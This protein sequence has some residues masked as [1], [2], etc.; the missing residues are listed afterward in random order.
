MNTDPLSNL[1][2]E[3][4]SKINRMFSGCEEIVGIGHVA[5]VI[6]G[7][8]SHSGSNQLNAY[9]G[10]EPSG[11]AHLGWM[12]L[13]ETIDNLLSEKVNVT[14]LL[15][16][17]HAWVND[18]FSRDMEK[19]SLAADYMSEVFR[20]LLDFPDEG[21]GPG[22]L[23]F[24]RASEMMDSGLHD[25]TKFLQDTLF[26]K[27]GERPLRD[28]ETTIPDIIRSE[29]IENALTR[30]FRSNFEFCGG[31]EFYQKKIEELRE[32]RRRQ[33]KPQGKTESDFVSSSS[34]AAAAANSVDL[35]DSDSPEL[36]KAQMKRLMKKFLEAE[37]A[38]EKEK[39]Q[40]V[41]ARTRSGEK[42]KKR[43]KKTE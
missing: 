10:L 31:S 27:S 28:L 36:S 9:I 29:P 39:G 33:P 15:A 12:V 25:F 5:N 11:K 32:Q 37:E 18:K 19:I 42:C 7:G 14:V 13:A 8:N 17:W 23:R 3:G 30:Q 20:V 35:V 4:R 43:Q 16:D 22:Q 34:T 1:D 6:S 24:I 40:A 41:S 2:D 21:D 26:P 38:E